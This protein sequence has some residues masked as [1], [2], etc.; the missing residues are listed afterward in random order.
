MY[1]TCVCTVRV[2]VQYMCMYST[3]VCTIG[4]YVQCMLCTAMP[5]N[6]ASKVRNVIG[7]MVFPFFFHFPPP[8]S[9]LPPCLCE[10]EFVLCVK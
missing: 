1:S 8:V 6:T 9:P 4:L 7:E 3:C 2:Y 10:R 5:G